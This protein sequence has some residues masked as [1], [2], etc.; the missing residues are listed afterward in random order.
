MWTCLATNN[1]SG[2]NGGCGR[3]LHA[4][5]QETQEHWSLISAGHPP[6][7]RLNFKIEEFIDKGPVGFGGVGKPGLTCFIIHGS[8]GF[9]HNWVSC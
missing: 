6:G 3:N 7:C 9:E 1:P 2:A 8:E 4:L 5:Q